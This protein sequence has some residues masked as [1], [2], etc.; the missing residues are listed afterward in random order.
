[1][2]SHQLINQTSKKTEWY[3][4]PAILAAARQLMGGI[5]LDPASSA[6]ANKH[7]QANV[8][9]TEPSYILY[10]ELIGGLPVRIYKDFGGLHH[11]RE[12]TGRVWLNHP[13]GQPEMP[14]QSGCTKKGCIERGWHTIGALP[15]SKDWIVRLVSEYVMGHTTE[16]VC[17]TFSATS[18]SWFQPLKWFPQIHI[19]PRLNYFDEEGNK[20]KGVTKGSCL[21]YLGDNVKGFAECF[22]KWGMVQVSYDFQFSDIK[23]HI[24][25]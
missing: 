7:V 21:T 4:D 20:V 3:T 19:S 8:Y 18:E 11:L 1:M 22:R 15:G 5:D 6:A 9:Y 23:F 14:C 2:N 25:S 16:A 13:F 24:K 17:L 12:W 10:D